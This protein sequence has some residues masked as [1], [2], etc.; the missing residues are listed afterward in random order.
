LLVKHRETGSAG[1]Q[2]LPPA[3]GRRLHEV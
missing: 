3:G 2:V 1:P